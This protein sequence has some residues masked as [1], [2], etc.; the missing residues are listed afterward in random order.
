MKVNL[1]DFASIPSQWVHSGQVTLS[2]LLPK[3]S[4]RFPS[5]PKPFCGQ[6]DGIQQSASWKKK[7]IIRSTIRT[8]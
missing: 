7:L 3:T 2:P 1:G 6:Q 8:R 4:S 5:I